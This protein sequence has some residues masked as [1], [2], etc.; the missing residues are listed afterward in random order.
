[1]N[2]S[3]TGIGLIVTILSFAAKYFKVDADEGQV[4]EAVESAVKVIGFITVIIGQLRRK[5]LIGGIV[6]R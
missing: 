5:D 2:L 1:M 3:L 6:R 4:T